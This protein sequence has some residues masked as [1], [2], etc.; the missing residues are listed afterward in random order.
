MYKK[1][2]KSVKRLLSALRKSPDHVQ[3]LLYVLDYVK[4]PYKC[5]S[6][7]TDTSCYYYTVE[8]NIEYL[9]S[10]GI[11]RWG[12]LADT[13][14]LRISIVEDN[15]AYSYSMNT[16]LDSM[17]LDILKKILL[18]KYKGNNALKNT[19]VVLDQYNLKI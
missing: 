3:D 10:F 2:I 12:W 11:D 14:L 8:N 18:F 13:E 15:G 16:R 7:N 17:E 9:L 5:I 1:N 6:N 19:L 4:E